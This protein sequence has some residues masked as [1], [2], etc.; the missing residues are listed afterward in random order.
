MAVVEYY[1]SMPSKEGY[2]IC[3]KVFKRQPDILMSFSVWNMWCEFEIN[4]YSF[5][6]F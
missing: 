6:L 1:S 2:A 4:C 5:P 3:S